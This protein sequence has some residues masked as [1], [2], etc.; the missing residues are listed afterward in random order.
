[1]G[2]AMKFQDIKKGQLFYEGGYGMNIEMVAL[3]D[4]AVIGDMDGRKQFGFRARNTQNGRE[5]NYLS[6]EGLSHYGP[7]LYPSP[8]Y[9]KFVGPDR[10]MT[11]PLLGGEDYDP[12][13][14][15]Q[16]ALRDPALLQEWVDANLNMS[17]ADFAIEK[18]AEALTSL[19]LQ[20]MDEEDLIEDLDELVHDAAAKASTDQVN[21]IPDD[22]DHDAEIDRAHKEASDA[23][24]GGAQS[25][26]AY[27]LRSGMSEKELMASVT[28]KPHP[29]PLGM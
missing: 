2:Q 22:A 7:S 23:C 5:Q 9:V 15:A 21:T 1:M 10:E 13:D 4:A 6:T 17:V 19:L 14:Q 12:D 8:A 3:S 25:Q 18:R 28:E 16:S 24:N 27:L 26:I 29:A 20:S 11:F